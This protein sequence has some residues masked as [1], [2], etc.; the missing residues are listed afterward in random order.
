MQHAAQRALEQIV[1]DTGAAA[2]VAVA[3]MF[4]RVGG[5]NTSKSRVRS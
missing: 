2:A 1:T 5:R 3:S 4:A